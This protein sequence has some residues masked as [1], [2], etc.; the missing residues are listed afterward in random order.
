MIGFLL[1]NYYFKRGY[2]FKHFRNL[3]KRK[4]VPSVYAEIIRE[5]NKGAWITL[6]LN[7]NTI[8]QGKIFSFDRDEKK[9]DYL[10]SITDAERYIANTNSTVKLKGERIVVNLKDTNMVE[11]NK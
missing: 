2:P 8:I 6:Y 11:F 3:T 4:Y 1:G 7:D 9:R 10:V 5:F